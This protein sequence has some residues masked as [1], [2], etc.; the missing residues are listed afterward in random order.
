MYSEEILA[1]R[2][3]GCVATRDIEE[4]ELI[5]SEEPALLLGPSEKK[6]G[7]SIT[8]SNIIVANLKILNCVCKSMKHVRKRSLSGRI[9]CEEAL[10]V[11]KHSLRGNIR[12]E[13]AFV[14][15]K[16]SLRGSIL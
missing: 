14:V 15:M 1:G 12:Y 2:G 9:R 10:V 13:E 5:L 16:H 3:V 6:R 11:R 4:G 8:R 7:V